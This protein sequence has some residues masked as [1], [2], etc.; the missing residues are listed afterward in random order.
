M[1]DR[2]P[3]EA[4]DGSGWRAQGEAEE[5]AFAVCHEVG[6]WLA[7]V[8]L[9]AHLLD[10]ELGA[11]E[12]ARAS[13]EID[14]LCARTSALLA[15]LRPLL[16]RAPQR[17]GPADGRD[18]VESV[19]ATLA[20]Q[21]LRGVSLETD[22]PEDLPPLAV[23]PGALHPVLLT[24]VFGAVEASRPDGAVC[25]RAAESSDSVSIAVEDRAPLERGFGDWRRRPLRGRPMGWAMADALVHKMGGRLEV[26]ELDPGTRVELVLPVMAATAA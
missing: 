25:I 23:D 3:G 15:Q 2:G 19:R 24:L 18:L 12:L 22:V 6:N 8:R 21:G 7:A 1:S 20:E 4:G 16:A 26:N 17:L 5:L 11:R 14:E 13:I 9:Q 10:A